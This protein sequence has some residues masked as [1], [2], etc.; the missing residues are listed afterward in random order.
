MVA[1]PILRSGYV[2]DVELAY[3]VGCT[4]EKLV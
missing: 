1:M 4:D 2:S 3:A